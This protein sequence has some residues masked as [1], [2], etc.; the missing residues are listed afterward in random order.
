M[1]FLE[2]IECSLKLVF[3]YIQTQ[4]RCFISWNPLSALPLLYSS[5]KTTAFAITSKA[6]EL[7][8]A[9]HQNVILPLISSALRFDILMTDFILPTAERIFLYVKSLQME[10]LRLFTVAMYRVSTAVLAVFAA[11]INLSKFVP[12]LRVLVS[13]CDDVL[14]QG[15]SWLV[16]PPAGQELMTVNAIEVESFF[17]AVTDVDEARLCA[18]VAQKVLELKSSQLNSVSVD[19]VTARQIES[20][21]LHFFK[22]LTNLQHHGT[23]VAVPLEEKVSSVLKDTSDAIAESTSPSSSG[24]TGSQVAETTAK[25]RTKLRL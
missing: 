10:T 17:H 20:S 23:T 7:L 14:I 5:W 18:G 1:L 21:V 13:L 22:A 12:G 25:A 6:S 8:T 4:I 19:D 2:L 16:P 3:M 9:F 15:V 24:I 11:L